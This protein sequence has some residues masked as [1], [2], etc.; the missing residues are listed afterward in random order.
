MRDC[1]QDNTDGASEQEKNKRSRV[2]IA[3]G[4]KSRLSEYESCQ[5]IL[6]DDTLYGEPHAQFAMTG[7]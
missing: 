5:K 3:D 4:Y 1:S 7:R 6:A 2:S